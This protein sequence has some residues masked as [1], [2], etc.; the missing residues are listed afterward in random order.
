[1]KFGATVSLLALALVASPVLADTAP[2]K[3]TGRWAQ[4]YTGRKADGAVVFGTLPNGLRYAIMH[5]ETPSDGVAMRMR[6]GSGSIVERDEEQGLAHFL[7]HMAFRGSK[8]IADGDVV[9]MLERQGL[10]F[11]PDT[12]AFTAQDETVYM[13]T[14]P[15]ADPTALDTG[16]T[17]F[18]EIGE[19][20]TLAPAA[21][22]AEKGV[23]LS[24]ERLR[25]VPA[26]RGIKA[27]LGNALA[28]TRAVTRWPIGLVDTIKGA[29]SERMRR[30][31]SA[32]YRPDNATLV[33]VGNIDPAKVE[34]EIKARF[35][36]WKPQ[37]KPDDVALGVPV[38][39]APAGEFVAS[40]AQDMLTLS[41]VRPADLRAET[42]AVDREWVLRTLGLTVLN[43]RLADRAAK[44]GSP[45]VSG[46]VGAVRQVFGSAGLTRIGITAAP[47]SWR[48]AL[49]AVTQEQRQLLQGGVD[50]QEL[51]RAVTE[52]LT[53]YQT[54]AAQA[55]TRKSGDIADELVQV[56][57]NDEISTSPAQDLA[58][59]QPILAAATPQE[60]NA[61]LHLAFAGQGPVLFRSAQSG[62]V[63][64]PLLVDAL[65]ADYARPLA[66]RQAEKAIV[67]PYDTFGAP[68]AILSQSVDKELGTT[69]VTFANGSRLMVK[70]TTF[71]KDKIRV[72]VGL[73][74][75][76]KGADPALAHALW[77]VD[78]VP[79]GGTG[80][81]SAGDLARWGESEGKVFGTYMTAGT[82]SFRLSGTTRSQDLVSQMQVLAAYA[83]DPGFRPEFAEKLAAVV[84]MYNGQI[85]ANA[86]GVFM[87][88]VGRVT[89]GGDGR[90]GQMPAAA[91]LAATRA[92]DLPLLL[93]GALGGP[94]DVVIVGDVSVADAIKATQATFGAGTTT[95]RLPDA[96]VHVSMEAGSAQSDVVTH[97]GR[98]DQA[99]YGEFWKLPDYF[100]APAASHTA[101]V[102]SAILSARLVDTVREK[103]G[104]TYSPITQAVSSTSLSG[105]GYLGV[106]L[107]TPPAN[108]DTF[109]AL[110]AGQIE[111]LA[112]KP[113]SADE[114]DRARRPLVQARTKEFEN[115]DFWIGQLPLVL[116]DPRVK[117]PVLEE[118]NGLAAVSA[119]DVQAFVRRY[120]QGKMPVTIIAKAK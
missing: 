20:L 9:Q 96:Q 94:A 8:N 98:T 28:G 107:E 91:D 115:N 69:M 72:S 54:A 109:R 74:Q 75:G 55:S 81:L 12:N 82:G 40:G 26:Y 15:K 22:E 85:E 60:V 73:G 65:K 76:R 7:E 49:A 99:Y 5:N 44:P 77:A 108:F 14:F 21:I 16:F 68:G 53:S 120:V 25:D 86:G 87:R 58:F 112:V 66:A 39:A 6:I 116:R 103:L 89:S 33:V 4:D 79:M 46:Q 2:L 111:D 45:Y 119:A 30:Y 80:K 70:H 18:R 57:N 113:V 63:T 84:P 29:T 17:L 93:R 114:L 95:P 67:W 37:G 62:A 36:D 101:D 32:N 35:S 104:M 23:V 24:E 88:E 105:M 31:Y 38:P 52:L 83:R 10:R 27:N 64:A 102:V 110:L 117:T 48:D 78:L 97:G 56:V 42:E 41:W 47:G 106:M 13:F 43:N 59:V 3:Q 19:R 11:G 118:A 34:A 71:E 1:M 50:A 100:E 51:K 90:Y 92:G 61:A